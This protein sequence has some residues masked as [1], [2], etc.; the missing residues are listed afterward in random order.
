[1]TSESNLIQSDSVCPNIAWFIAS[2][3]AGNDQCIRQALFGDFDDNWITACGH[4]DPLHVCSPL[5]VH[6][7][8]VRHCAPTQG[9]RA[10]ELNISSASCN[11]A[12][13][14]VDAIFVS[15]VASPARTLTLTL[16]LTRAHTRTRRLPCLSVCAAA[17]AAG[18]V[19]CSPLGSEK[20]PQRRSGAAPQ[21][22]GRRQQRHRG[23]CGWVRLRGGRGGG[24]GEGCCVLFSG[25][26]QCVCVYLVCVCCGGG[27]RLLRFVFVCWVMSIRI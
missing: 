5:C 27:A 18:K 13:A 20:W 10:S 11:V 12:S 15:N 21:A 8:P 22:Q 19:H 6:E 16:S 3:A 1:M 2:C 24:V 26:G 14:C 17:A 25:V 23:E 9:E 4:K 7:V